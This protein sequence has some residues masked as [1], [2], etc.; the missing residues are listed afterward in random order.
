M[1]PRTA[2]ARLM[3][4]LAALLAL[5]MT[6]PLRAVFGLLRLDE[7]GVAARAL[8][9]P[10]WWGGAEELQIGRVRLGSVDAF[11]SPLPLLA[12]RARLNI[13]RQLG[14]PDD[15]RGA[16]TVGWGSRGIDDVTGT[17]PLAAALAPLPV[18]S[19]DLDDVSV[20]FAGGRCVNAQGQ[21]RARLMAV[22][23]GLNLA[24]GLTGTP[25]CDGAALL[26]PLAGQS[27]MERL[28]VRI[29]ADGGLQ[30]TMRVRTSDPQL[31]AVLGAS[32]FRAVGGEQ[33]LRIDSAL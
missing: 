21:V 3:L 4:A 10:V 28:E 22:I 33:V 11:L 31:G 14:A 8:R 6:L 17:L 19:V 9:G 18:S 13:R 16:V 15:I 1:F 32:G 23:G 25:R 26:L 24:N 12:G 7:M 30:A 2:R 5:L 27:G 29:A 20:R